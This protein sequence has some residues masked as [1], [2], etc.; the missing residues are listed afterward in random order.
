MNKA[1]KK[2]RQDISDY[3]IRLWGDDCIIHSK[4][5]FCC[6][7]MYEDELIGFGLQTNFDDNKEEKILKLCLDIRNSLKK[8]DDYLKGSKDDE[9]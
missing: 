8:L 6:L 3:D 7:D 1:L 2:I 5:I 9:C 4:R